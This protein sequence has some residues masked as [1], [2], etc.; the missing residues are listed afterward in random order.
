[1]ASPVVSPAVG[2]RSRA[3]SP[4]RSESSA[5]EDRAAFGDDVVFI[6]VAWR[7]SAAEALVS[8]GTGETAASD[9]P[10]VCS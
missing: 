3:L 2:E 1:M 7:T 9:G 6:F 4:S 5:I 10:L 8:L